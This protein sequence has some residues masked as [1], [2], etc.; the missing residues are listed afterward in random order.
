M[1]ATFKFEQL[2]NSQVAIHPQPKGIVQFWG[3]YGFASFPTLF[4]HYL[5]QRIF[6]D[7]YTIVTLLFSLSSLESLGRSGN[8]L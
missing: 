5:L 2:S 6:E 1:E 7:G 4:Y 3:G 8:T